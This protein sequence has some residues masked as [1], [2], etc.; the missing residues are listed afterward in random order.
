MKKLTRTLLGIALVTAALIPGFCAAQEYPT[1]P[2]TLII[3]FPPGGS[4]DMIGR[5]LS[6]SL[7]RLWKQAIIVE[8]RAGGGTSVGSNYVAKSPADGYRLLLVS[9]S[10]TTNAATRTDQPFDP[11]KDLKPVSMIGRGQIGVVAGPKNSIN[12]LAD[13][14][15][16]AKTKTIFYGTAGIGSTQHFNA[17]LLNDALGIKMVAVPYKGGQEALVDTAG[18][19]IDVVVGAVGGMMPFIDGGKVKLIG[20]MS[21]THSKALPNV[22]TTV[23]AGFPAALTDNYWAIFVPSATPEGVVNRINVGIKTVTHNEEGRKFLTKLDS[24]PADMNPAEVTAYVKKEIEYWTKLAK[25]L[26]ISAN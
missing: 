22:Q 8:N 12:S 11:V 16:E 9:S 4:N 7:G 13:L 26:N 5:Y 18:A 19:R 10:Y 25:A 17:E 20:I 6:D 14:V 24:E 23:E 1:K 21:K 15:R 2:I 3:P